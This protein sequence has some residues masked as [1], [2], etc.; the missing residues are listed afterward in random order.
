MAVKRPNRPN[1]NFLICS[2]DHS[3]PAPVSLFSISDLYHSRIYSLP[4][5]RLSEGKDAE[6]AVT[7]LSRLLVQGH[8]RTHGERPHLRH[9]HRHTDGAS[10]GSGGKVVLL[11]LGRVSEEIHRLDPLTGATRN[12]FTAVTAVA[13]SQ[14]SA[15]S[16]RLSVVSSQR[17]EPEA[18]GRR[19]E[20]GGRKLEVGSQK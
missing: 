20:G 2:Y 7:S 9:V 5:P 16:S 3:T 17:N 1:R 4:L 10:H 8:L 18:R 19:S 12:N 15:A 14:F 6:S 11:L 13:S